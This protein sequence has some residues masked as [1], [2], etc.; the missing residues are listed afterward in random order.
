MSRHFKTLT[1]SGLNDVWDEQMRIRYEHEKKIRE[2]QRLAVKE[3]WKESRLLAHI[4]DTKG[5]TFWTL[6]RIRTRRPR[7]ANG[8]ST[9]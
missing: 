8:C 2:A 9:H 6:K 5:H 1:L 4:L 3:A 7:L